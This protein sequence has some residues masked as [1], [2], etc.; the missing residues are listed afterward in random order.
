M[1]SEIN[2]RTKVKR[3]YQLIENVQIEEE[4]DF[5]RQNVQNQNMI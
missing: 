3:G 2:K 1:E 4:A 5:G